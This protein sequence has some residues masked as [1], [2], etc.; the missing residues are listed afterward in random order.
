VALVV[1]VQQSRLGSKTILEANRNNKLPKE[2]TQGSDPTLNLGT[3]KGKCKS[4][5]INDSFEPPIL[6][7]W[8]PIEPLTRVM[9]SGYQRPRPVSREN[10]R[11]SMYHPAMFVLYNELPLFE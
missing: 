8:Q 5:Q 2:P 11:P 1:A 4:Y 9:L 7:S 10:L 6:D 3:V